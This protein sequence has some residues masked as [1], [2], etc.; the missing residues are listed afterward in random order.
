MRIISLKRV[1]L[2]LLKDKKIVIIVM[3]VCMLLGI[4]N[5]VRTLGSKIREA[6]AGVVEYEKKLEDYNNSLAILDES[7]ATM[8]ENL[9]VTKR[10]YEDIKDYCENSI[11]MKLDANAIWMGEVQ[12]ACQGEVDTGRVMNALMTHYDSVEMRGFISERM[13]ISEEFLKEL[14]YYS[15]ASNTLRF[16][17]YY[18]SEEGANELMDCIIQGLEDAKAEISVAQ[19]GYTLTQQSLDI[20]IQADTG[21]QNNQNTYRNNYKNYNNSV[22]DAEKA[23]QDK[24]VNRDK[25]ASDNMPE[26]ASPLGTKGKTVHFVKGFLLG[27]VSG[28]VLLLIFGVFRIL[29]GTKT[30]DEECLRGMGIYTFLIDGADEKQIGVISEDIELRCKRLHKETIVL[31]GISITDENVSD[32][33][34]DLLSQKSITLVCTKYLPDDPGFSSMIRDGVPF[35]LYVRK[36]ISKYRELNDA[37]DRL[38]RYDTEIIGGIFNNAVIKKKV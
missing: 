26:P 21:V 16:Y 19:G 14:L 36:N 18:D 12:Y 30:R 5:S 37:V 13:G 24:I 34:K 8:K 6:D 23:I 3:A 4:L 22:T 29:F 38:S 9:E 11:Y 17:F 10:Q 28:V 32:K 35:M 7:I 2:D 25:N 31:M 1:V 33:L 20:G 27:A 15:S